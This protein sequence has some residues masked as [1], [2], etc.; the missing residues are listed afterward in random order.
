MGYVGRRENGFIY[1]REIRF[2]GEGFGIV[3]EF[4]DINIF[5]CLSE[6]ILMFN[7]V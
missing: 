1:R 2:G 3:E 6:L 7:G 5:G 4:L